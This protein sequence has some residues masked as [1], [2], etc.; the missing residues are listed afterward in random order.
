MKTV[1][2]ARLYALTHR[3][4]LHELTAITA[5]D[6]AAQVQALTGSRQAAGLARAAW[7]AERADLTGAG[8]RLV[9]VG[10]IVRQTWG[11]MPQVRQA[12]PAGASQEEG[13]PETR[14]DAL[15]AAAVPD[16]A[17]GSQGPGTYRPQLRRPP[18]RPASGGAEEQENRSEPWQ[19]DV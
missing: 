17:S 8:V 18:A 15:G 14:P 10:Q 5:G 2:T 16:D 1:I 7:G 13:E 3:G 11:S 4:T 9:A 19:D 6:L 12:R